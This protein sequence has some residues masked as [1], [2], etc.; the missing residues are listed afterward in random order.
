MNITR[1]IPYRYLV[2][3]INRLSPKLTARLR[4]RK[5]FHR[6]LH[7]KNPQ[8]L[9]EK[10]L[11]L[12]LLSDT[13]EWTRLADKYLVRKYVKDR[14]L[15]SILVKLYGKWNSV[16]DINWDKL[17]HSFVMKT[18]NGCGT[19]LIVQDK[20]KL[21]TSATKKEL[22]SW[23]HKDIWGE[24][25]EFHYKKIKPCIIAEELLV[26]S[27]EDREISESIIDYKIWC[28]NGRPYSFL[29][30]SNRTEDAVELSSYDLNWSYHP[31]HSVFGKEHLRRKKGIPRPKLLEEMKNVASKLS[32]GFPEVRVD[33]YYVNNKIYFG[34]MTFTSL[35]GTM[36]Y[37]TSEYLLEMG[38]QIDL[39]NVKYK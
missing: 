19:V 20:S 31:E 21:D 27:D 35:G 3:L 34:E 30:C 12:S 32:E 36:N 14:G 18:N 38:Q 24:T 11:H 29:V 15:E 22:D 13:S 39:V 5:I 25:A 7:L 37:Y 8:D 28:F 6:R 23:L 10:I 17:P 16:E 1:S 26:L 9:N 2:R 33:L 4:F